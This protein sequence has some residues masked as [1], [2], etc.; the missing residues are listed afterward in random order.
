MKLA[1]SSILKHTS[2]THCYSVLPT[3]SS[4]QS[5]TSVLIVLTVIQ[6]HTQHTNAF[7]M[8]NNNLVVRKSKM[9]IKNEARLR[10]ER[11]VK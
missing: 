2:I 4:A 8:H 3:T 7:G 9:F 11:T 1:R 5:V 6:C 10:A